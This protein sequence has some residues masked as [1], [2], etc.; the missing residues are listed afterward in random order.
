MTLQ[1]LRARAQHVSRLGHQCF[2]GQAGVTGGCGGVFQYVLD[3]VLHAVFAVVG[4]A[5]LERDLV[6]RQETDP[7]HVIDDPVRVGAHDGF[8]FAAICFCDARRK[9]G[10]Y[11]VPLQEHHLAAFSI[12]LG[13]AQGDHFCT[14]RT[15]APD[16]DQLAHIQHGVK[17][18]LAESAD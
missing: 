5:H 7:V 1:R 4:E 13:E 17:G 15:D 3:P 11:A 6:C 9:R 14:C 2:H 18:F 10:R 12:L 8:R 16:L